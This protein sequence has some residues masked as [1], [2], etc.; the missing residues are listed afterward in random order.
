MRRM[1]EGLKE[2]F[3]SLKSDSKNSKYMTVL[4]KQQIKQI[5]NSKLNLVRKFCI[6]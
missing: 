6:L 5:Q 3:I 4:D 2:S 1:Y